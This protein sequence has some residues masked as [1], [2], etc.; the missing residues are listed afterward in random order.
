MQ[1]QWSLDIGSPSPRSRATV[2]PGEH[3]LE[4]VLD[5]I[6]HDA[7]QP[8]MVELVASDGARLGV[9]LGA[10]NS[11][12]AFNPSPEPPYFISVGDPD[13]A[14]EDPVFYL[15]GHWTEFPASALVPNSAA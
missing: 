2:V 6:E 15:H 9:G 10:S 1:V 11:V 14:E 7:P 3:E 12:L 5:E 4:S 8:V 13:A